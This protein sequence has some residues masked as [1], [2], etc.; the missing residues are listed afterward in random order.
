M[1]D[2]RFVRRAMLAGLVLGTIAACGPVEESGAAKAAAEAEPM[3]A[4]IAQLTLSNPSH[5]ARKDEVVVLGLSTLGVSPDSSGRLAVRAAEQE[6]PAQLVDS[7]A[8]G[9]GDALAFLA[10]FAAAETR[11]FEILDTPAPGP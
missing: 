1:Y 8:D 2:T 6:L 5:F 4:P 3:V 7:D 10:D 9:S 11:S